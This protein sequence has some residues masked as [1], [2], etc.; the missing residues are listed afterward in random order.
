[1]KGI[2]EIDLE[3]ETTYRLQ[4][5]LDSDGDY[6]LIYGTAKDKGGGLRALDIHELVELHI[7]HKSPIRDAIT[8][9]ELRRKQ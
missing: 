5:S 1:M 8:Q 7:N 3:E 9:N 4:Y 2:L 6:S